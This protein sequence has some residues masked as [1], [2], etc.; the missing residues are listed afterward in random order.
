MDKKNN[1]IITFDNQINILRKK[2]AE[3]EVSGN[4]KQAQKKIDE[5]EDKIDKKRINLIKVY[6]KAKAE[7][8]AR[9]QVEERIKMFEDI[10]QDF[11]NI[12]GSIILNVELAIDDAFENDEIKYSLNQVIKASNHAK[13]LID[14]ILSLKNSS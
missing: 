2:V 14:Q 1:S 12:L 5:I 10:A 11:N 6:K 9:K 7:K 13:Y 8:N 3:I 4:C